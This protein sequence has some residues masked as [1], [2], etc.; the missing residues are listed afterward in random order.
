MSEISFKIRKA[1]GRCLTRCPNIS[2][3]FVCSMACRE[4][5]HYKGQT[6]NREVKCEYEKAT[7]D[8]GKGEV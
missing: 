1:D 6:K 4:C 2:G 7:P 5:R 8:A 3:L